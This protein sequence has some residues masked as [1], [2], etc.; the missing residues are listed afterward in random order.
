MHIYENIS[1]HSNAQVRRGLIDFS[2]QTCP[3]FTFSNVRGDE[4]MNCPPRSTSLDKK[5]IKKSHSLPR[6][7]G[8]SVSLTLDD[9]YEVLAEKT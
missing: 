4:K 5:S 9:S 6:K 3:N 1:I 2:Y 8:Q 7:M